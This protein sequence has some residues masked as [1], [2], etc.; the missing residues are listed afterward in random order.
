MADEILIKEPTKNQHVKIYSVTLGVR[1]Y[2]YSEAMKSQGLKAYVRSQ[3]ASERLTSDLMAN[4]LSIIVFINYRPGVNVGMYLEY[5]GDTYCI[6][7]CDP[8]F[9][10]K[11]E[12]KIVAKNVPIPES[13]SE[14]FTS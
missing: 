12:L 2:P 9:Y 14:E 8:N 1:K 4:D 10:L 5:M 13:S 7:S 3:S 11:K 6:I